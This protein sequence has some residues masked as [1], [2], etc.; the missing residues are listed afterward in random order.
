MQL[1][2]D[3]QTSSSRKQVPVY[4]YLFKLSRGFAPVSL[5]PWV[6]SISLKTPNLLKE[7]IRVQVTVAIWE[8]PNIGEHTISHLRYTTFECWT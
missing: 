2:S 1:D 6:P 4:S 8:N 5:T 7:T 3:Y